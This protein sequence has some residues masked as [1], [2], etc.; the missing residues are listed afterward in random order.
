MIVKKAYVLLRIRRGPLWDIVL[1]GKPP[2][3]V[4]AYFKSKA[5]AQRIQKKFKFKRFGIYLL[6][7][8]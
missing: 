4:V 7:K 5:A 3:G 1:R 6:S 2:K 8:V